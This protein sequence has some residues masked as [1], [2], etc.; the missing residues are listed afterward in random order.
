[1][2]YCSWEANEIEWLVKYDWWGRVFSQSP[3]Q[4][5]NILMLFGISI[6]VCVFYSSELFRVNLIRFPY[7]TQRI[8]LI[9]ITHGEAICQKLVETTKKISMS[10]RLITV[11]SRGQTYVWTNDIPHKWHQIYERYVIQIMTNL[12]VCWKAN[13]QQ[14]TLP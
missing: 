2:R 12:T 10:L 8:R 11:K 6:Q 9:F 5:S 13:Y 7:Q 14:R 1:M 4:V 3:V